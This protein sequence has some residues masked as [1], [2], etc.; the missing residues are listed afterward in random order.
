MRGSI[1]RSLYGLRLPSTRLRIAVLLAMPTAIFSLRA[2]IACGAETAAKPM[3]WTESLRL[4]ALNSPELKAA[5]AT[6]ASSEAQV[7][8]VTGSYFPT[9]ALKA[10]YEHIDTTLAA[11]RAQSYSDGYNTV[12]E[13]KEVLFNGFADQS[14]IDQERANL[15][16]AEANL[17]IIRARISADLKTSF[18]GL[19][20]AKQSLDRADD[21]IK[22]R[23]ANLSLVQLRFEGGREN[24]GSVMLSEAYLRQA[25]LER[26]QALGAIESATAALAKTMGVE[27]D[28]IGGTLGEVPL[29]P[30][31]LKVNF[32]E[33]ATLSPA[34]WQAIEQEQSAR[35][36]VGIARGRLLPYLELTGSIGKIDSAWFPQND[37]WKVALGLTIPLFN[38]G[39]DYYGL[40]SANA[41]FTAASAN[42][43]TA[44]RQLLV[45]LK[46]TH[47]AYVEAVSKEKVDQAFLAAARTRADIGRG[48]YNNGL[49][50]F[51]EWDGIEND[52]INREKNMLASQRDRVSA[53]AAWEQA[54]GKGVIP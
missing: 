49:L 1:F 20:Y 21:V 39:G 34:H 12:L 5:R 19:V 9:L 6:V 26:L 33:L 22:R 52:L 31:P 16:A 7:K 35:S 14:R 54:Q 50:S 4:T 10:G 23:K 42:R 40:Q 43:E 15:K 11:S 48:K 46:Q 17:A 51:E 38:G 37:Q 41:S 53:E 30:P 27:P 3:T 32:T 13:G 28:S 25:E 18:E 8:S 45:T 47:S 2:D 44:D 24:K 36:A 29:A